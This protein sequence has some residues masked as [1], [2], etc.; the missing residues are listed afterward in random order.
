MAFKI[1]AR[2][3]LELGAEELEQPERMAQIIDN[4]EKARERSKKS[5]HNKPLIHVLGGF[6]YEEPEREG[7][8]ICQL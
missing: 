8:L 2:T 1:T 4:W 6:E 3:I 5:T 7:C